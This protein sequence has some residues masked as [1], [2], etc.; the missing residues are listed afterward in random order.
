MT[1]C[2]PSRRTLL[3]AL[4]LAALLPVVGAAR[5]GSAR[6]QSNPI[7]ATDL[8]VVTITDRTVIVTWTTL[9]PDAAGRLAP[10]AAD[11]ELRLAPADS[12]RAPVPVWSDPEPTPF[13]YAEVD[14]LEP[15]RAYRFE[16]WS[17]GVRAIPAL[18][19]TTLS[20]GTPEITGEFTT[21]MPPPGRPLRTIALA[22]DIHYGE[23]VS[24][25]LVAGLPPG[26]RQDVPPYPEAMLAAL[27]D[28]LRRPDR[29]AAHLLIAGDLTDEASLADSRAVRAQLDG[30]GLLGTDY[31]VVRGN[32]DRP[33]TG[34][35]YAGCTPAPAAHHDCWAEAFT[36]RQQLVE[37]EIGGLRVLGLDTSELDGSG[38]TIDRPQFDLFT[39]RL[40]ADPDR[41][42]L[43]FSHHPVTRES[44]YTNLA[45]PGFVLNGRDSAELQA[46]YERTPGVF[47]HHSGHTHRNRRTRPDTGCAVEFLEVAA[48]K[49]YPG[50]YSLLRLYEGGYMVNFYKTRTAAARRWS[51]T[52]RGEY[53]GLLPD[54]TLGTTA[55]RNHVVLRDFS[56]LG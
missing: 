24:G 51:A 18:S 28:D 7:L 33:H 22:N 45:G 14:D 19:L 30:W 1:C 29:D 54:Y 40:R 37:H 16:A 25:L 15:G 27:L 12:P 23:E 4:G 32:H 6:A 13:H 10:I 11:A 46:S 3:G 47:L 50:G 43:V 39:E 44:G 31:L 17:N 34:P 49:E 9:T 35:D 5:P 52:T 53:F 36:P 38:G 20:P 56:G 8:E 41:P 48:V 21:L 42:T 2:G 26:F 55:D